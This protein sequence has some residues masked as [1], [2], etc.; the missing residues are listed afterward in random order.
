M[1]SRPSPRFWLNFLIF[2][3]QFSIKSRQ[4]DSEKNRS[5]FFIAIGLVQRA[6]KVRQLLFAHKGFERKNWRIRAWRGARPRLC[7]CLRAKGV[8]GRIG[9]RRQSDGALGA[10]AGTVEMNG[11]QN[12]GRQVG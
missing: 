10:L 12:A 9:H 11:R 2:S 4:T 7:R 1:T 5:L 8:K 3:G 6:V